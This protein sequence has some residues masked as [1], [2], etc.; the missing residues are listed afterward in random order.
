MWR[1]NGFHCGYGGFGAC[2][3]NK[4]VGGVGAVAFGLECYLV[5]EAGFKIEYWG[6]EPLVGGNVARGCV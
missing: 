1:R 4:L 5:G 2:G 3:E 6:E